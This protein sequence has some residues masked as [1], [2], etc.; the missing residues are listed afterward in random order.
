MSAKPTGPDSGLQRLADEGYQVEVREQHVLLRGVPFVRGGGAIGTGSLVCP[1]VQGAG[2]V[3][4]PENHQVWWTEEYPCF[5]NGRPIEQIRNEDGARE[6]FAGCSIQH[7]FSNKP[8][9]A[10]N[11]VDHYAKL[12]HYVTLIQAQAKAID[13]NVDARGERQGVPAFAARSPFAYPDS[14]SARAEIL[15]TSSRLALKRVAIVGVG[16]TGAYV[17]DQV[18]KTPV[19]EIHLF[20]GDVFLDHNAFRSPGAASKEDLAHRPLKTDYFKSKYEAM[21]LGIFTHPN[22]LDAANVGELV[23]FDFVFV[24]VDRGSSRRLLFDHLTAQRIPFIDVGMDLQLVKATGKLIGTCRFTMCTPDQQNHFSQY[25]PMDDDDAEAVYR[26]NIQIAD[27]NALNAQLAVMKWK[28]HFGF[29]QDDFHAHNGTFS[30]NSMSLA[31]DV[32]VQPRTA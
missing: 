25:A 6:L 7:R 26:Q 13:P 5:A 30:V 4:P 9:G 23:D 3:A 31:R 21:H 11:F 2:A 1:Y 19:D 16:G 12:V 24:C 17:L 29:Y 8:D 20:D 14:A 27:M 18:A 28:Q 32:L 22:H 10:N 15:A